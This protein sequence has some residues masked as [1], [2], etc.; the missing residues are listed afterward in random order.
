MERSVGGTPN[1]A[2]LN[3]FLQNPAISQMMQSLLSNPQYM[4]QVLCL[5]DDIVS[6]KLVKCHLKSFVIHIFFDLNYRSS[7]STHRRGVWLI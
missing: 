6:A 1:V 7:I 4:N 3:Q 2:Q 5:Y